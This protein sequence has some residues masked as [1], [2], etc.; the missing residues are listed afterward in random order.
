MTVKE[1]KQGLI[2]IKGFSASGKTTVARLVEYSLRQD[3]Y[4]VVSLDGDELRGI[5]GNKWGYDVVGRK[6]LAKAYFRLCSHLSSQGYF[7]IISAVA[8]FDEIE[9][10]VRIN[11]PNSM[12]VLLDVPAEERILR[13]SKTKKIFHNNNNNDSDYDFPKKSDVIIK[14]H[15]GVTPKNSAKKI[16]EYYQNFKVNVAD[17]N[18]S[19][20]WKDYYLKDRAPTFPSN[21]AEYVLQKINKNQNMLEIG[22]GNGRDAVFFKK[23]GLKVDAIDRSD[24]AIVLCKTKYKDLNIGFY[25]GEI[26][27][28][29]E[30]DNNFKYDNIYCR[31]VLHAMPIEEEIIL[32]QNSFEL[33]KKKGMLFIE[34]RSIND[35]M[36]REGEVISPTERISGHYRRFI[37]MEELGDRLKNAGFEVLS[38]FEKE[39]A[40]KFGNDNPVVIRAI[41]RK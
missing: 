9:E 35:Q 39:N 6:E 38:L 41:V 25:H 22:C 32:I 13:D 26:D 28:I 4:N 34:C 37:I 27:Q 10:W 2:W 11:I 29:I 30:I 16:I 20:H 33:L 3:G 21:F 8:M 23:N 5:F 31:F 7:V 40:A 14:N 17:R 12:Q 19:K 15:G 36:I 1:S 18:R 24:D